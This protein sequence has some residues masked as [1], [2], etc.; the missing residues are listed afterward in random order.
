MRDA[1]EA[2][3]RLLY[4]MHVDWDWIRQRPQSLAGQ[5]AREPGLDLLVAYLPNWRR[6]RLVRTGSRV[7]R[8]PLPRVP[9][10][11]FAP[12]RA[13]NDVLAKAGLAVIARAWRPTAV[14]LTYPT[15]FGVLPSSLR[16]RPIFYDC[17]DLATGFAV[18][19]SDQ[20]ALEKLER[21]LAAKAAATF[22]S[23]RFIGDVIRERYDP[24]GPVVLVR[25]GYDSGLGRVEEGA[26]EFTDPARILRLGYVGTIARWF[27]W[28]LMLRALDDDPRLELHLWGPSDGPTPSHDRIRAHGPVTHS[29]IPA[30][31]R[32]MDALIMPFV[33][34]DLIRGVDPVKLYEYV[35][36]GKPAIAVHYPEIERFEGLVH[37]YRTADEL[38]ELL[39]RLRTDRPSM[40][41]S[42]EESQRFLAGSTWAA[43][44]ATIST[45]IHERVGPA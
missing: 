45:T 24:A 11:R 12:I 4:V 40:R 16:S 38:A 9:L 33:L 26:A 6:G 35:A 14:W 8:V 27:D 17:M 30:V 44:A 39:R 19:P 5:L 10:S 13:S 23:S 28:P 18:E 32:P 34:S 21:R 25:N 31:V 15:L 3:I 37:L 41:P 22:V 43:R 1:D 29:D 36:L 2:P 7:A 20:R 42:A